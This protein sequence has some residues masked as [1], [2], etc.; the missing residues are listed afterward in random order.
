MNTKEPEVGGKGKPT[1]QKN[2]LAP[3]NGLER[4]L[5]PLVGGFSGFWEEHVRRVQSSENVFQ[6]PFNQLPQEDRRA[7][8]QQEF[9]DMY[10]ILG[11]M[12]ATHEID[13]D[14]LE[15][16]FGDKGEGAIHAIIALINSSDNLAIPR[17]KPPSFDEY[18][19][20]NYHQSFRGVYHYFPIGARVSDIREL[21]MY[22]VTESPS[23]LF[24][25][26]KKQRTLFLHSMAASAD[27]AD[28]YPDGKP[29][30]QATVLI[31]ASASRIPDFAPIGRLQTA[32]DLSL[33]EPGSVYLGRK[34]FAPIMRQIIGERRQ[35]QSGKKPPHRIVLI[36]DIGRLRGEEVPLLYSLLTAPMNPYT[37]FIATINPPDYLNNRTHVPTD[38]FTE[39]LLGS[40]SEAAKKGHY[41]PDDPVWHHAAILPPWQYLAYEQ[42]KVEPTEYWI[43]KP[44]VDPYTPK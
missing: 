30:A 10:G 8:G 16:H 17:L 40:L 22:P 32:G 21:R 19:Y 2:D 15:H 41:V 13:P 6:V 18:K 25:G 27:W 37:H 34:D 24:I 29:K 14:L 35:I 31:A 12:V 39:V 5:F 44:G 33:G 9:I 36:D 4:I 43:I 38:A 20:G 3:R 42:N 7:Q 11:H 23:I 28:R 1:E 26:D